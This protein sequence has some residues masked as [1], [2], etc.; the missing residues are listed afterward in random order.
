VADRATSPAGTQTPQLQEQLKGEVMLM[1]NLS[2]AEKPHPNIVKTVAARSDK[3]SGGHGGIAVVF[4]V[5]MEMCPGGSLLDRVNQSIRDGVPIPDEEVVRNFGAITSA[6]NYLHNL[7][8]PLAHRD[9]KLE[10]VLVAEDKTLRLCDFGSVSDRCGPILDR[11]DRAAEEERIQRFTTPHFRA[12]EML[13][14]YS[15]LPIDTRVDI[16]ALGCVL[17]SL[18]YNKHPFP[19]AAGVSIL[20]A[21]YRVPHNP[22]RPQPIITLIRACLAPHPDHRPSGVSILRYCAALVKLLREHDPRSEEVKKGVGLPPLLTQSGA[23]TLKLRPEILTGPDGT[24]VLDDGASPGLPEGFLSG[25]RRAAR[26]GAVKGSGGATRRRRQAPSAGMGDLSLE[27]QM[28]RM[29]LSDGSTSTSGG[30]SAL[31]ARSKARG[32]GTV[33]PAPALAPPPKPATSSAPRT[34]APSGTSG[35]WDEELGEGGELTPGSP[36]DAEENAEA[37]SSSF[38]WGLRVQE[39]RRKLHGKASPEHKAVTAKFGEEGDVWAMEQSTHS[40]ATKPVQ[41]LAPPV[42]TPAQPKP[43]PASTQIKAMLFAPKEDDYFSFE[44]H[45]KKPTAEPEDDVFQPDDAFDAGDKDAFAFD[46]APPAPVAQPARVSAKKD[47]PKAASALRPPGAKASDGIDDLFSA[48]PSVGT[49]SVTAGHDDLFQPTPAPA[50]RLGNLAD[51]YAAPHAPPVA[52]GY[53]MAPHAPPVAMGYGMAPGTYGAVPG[54]MGYGS[55]SYG[56]PPASGAFPAPPMA[57]GPYMGR[58]GMAVPP[59]PIPPT[60]SAGSSVP[61]SGPASKPPARTGLDALDP[62]A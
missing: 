40:T 12:P 59:F 6:V 55:M 62:F 38:G 54:A 15:P 3:V 1:L 31:A 41:P 8:K 5:V 46:D 45:G 24:D 39:D 17:F 4:R 43:A 35:M 27:E 60:S 26:G 32:A 9:L 37:T 2:R 47:A 29:G 18:A 56:V 10:N 49:S 30:S 25:P 51:L 53:G 28:K 11:D 58:P 57:G 42:A 19:E 7:E 20:A 13:D 22:Y 36:D 48:A 21:N 61:V 50:S 14:L 44:D 16:W 23:D 33:T 34:V 52:M